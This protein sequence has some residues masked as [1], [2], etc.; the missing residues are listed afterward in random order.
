ME[1]QIQIKAGSV[2]ATAKLNDT[3]SADAIWQAFAVL[4][5]VQTVGLSTPKKIRRG[6]GLTP[7]LQLEKLAD[8][9]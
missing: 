3:K 7:A 6:S 8:S 1:R 2:T 9:V 4:L 5:P